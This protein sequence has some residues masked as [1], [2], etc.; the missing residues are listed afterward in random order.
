METNTKVK[1]TQGEWKVIEQRSIL[2]PFLLYAD[3]R[4]IAT[5][6][7]GVHSSYPETFEEVEANVKF[8]CEAVNNYD[9]LKED[10][11]VLL[12]ALKSV[13]NI[14]SF[15]INT[16]PTGDNRNRLTHV[17]ILSLEA[18]R[19]VESKIKISHLKKYNHGKE[20]I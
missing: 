2:E 13:Q 14:V 9:K 8:I 4:K 1:R 19:Q 17:N 7:W 3:K 15:L 6:H 5:M 16:T 18:I 12:N 10:N 11:E 20:S